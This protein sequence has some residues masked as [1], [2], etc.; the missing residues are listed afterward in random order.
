MKKIIITVIA[1]IVLT[2]P[3]E[4]AKGQDSFITSANFPTVNIHTGINAKLSVGLWQFEPFLQLR[5]NFQVFEES[6][7]AEIITEEG[8][9]FEWHLS[10]FANTLFNGGIRFRIT[11][12]D[13]IILGVTQGGYRTPPSSARRGRSDIHFGY[14]HTQNLSQR[15]S[16][17]FYALQTV[18]A[19][20]VYG[21][22]VDEFIVIPLH[23]EYLATAIGVRLNY[24]IA[25]NLK[26]N[27][28]LGYTRLYSVRLIRDQ[29]ILRVRNN[30]L[31]RNLID[32]SVGIHYH[33]GRRQEIHRQRDGGFQ[34]W[35]NHPARHQRR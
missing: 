14:V 11:D 30:V 10:G 2:A 34:R 21:R 16:L 12:R 20:S 19:R 27:M 26:L 13:R 18:A 24:E 9:S 35:G 31:T 3:F 33:I 23:F 25:R 32:I 5:P 15:V 6:V 8:T 28:Q 4:E 7:T 22:R 17:D 1:T 29:E